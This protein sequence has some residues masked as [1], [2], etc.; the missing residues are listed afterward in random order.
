MYVSPKSPKRVAQKFYFALLR[1]E[2]T[3]ASHGLSAIAELLVN[4]GAPAISLEWLKLELS[5]F[6]YW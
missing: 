2:V 4:V 5:S 1:I 6:V 3:R